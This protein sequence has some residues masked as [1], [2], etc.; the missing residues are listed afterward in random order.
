MKLKKLNGSLQGLNAKKRFIY[1][2][3]LGKMN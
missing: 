3:I 1:R 2:K